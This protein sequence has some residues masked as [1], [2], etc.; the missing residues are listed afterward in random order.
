MCVADI[1][2]ERVPDSIWRLEKHA[3]ETQMIPVERMAFQG[4]HDGAIVCPDNGDWNGQ[5]CAQPGLSAAL[6]GSRR[7]NRAQHTGLLRGEY[8]F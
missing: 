7:V 4:E 8:D 5:L 2:N 3:M 1:G 6:V